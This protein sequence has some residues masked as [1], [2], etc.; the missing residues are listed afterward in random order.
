MLKETIED[1]PL[2]RIFNI[3][4]YSVTGTREISREGDKKL[5]CTSDVIAN[6]EATKPSS[7]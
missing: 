4:V 6:L 1:G 3:K 2:T 7:P 5:S